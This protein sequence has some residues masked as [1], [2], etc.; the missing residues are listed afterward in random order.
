MIPQPPRALLGGRRVPAPRLA[1]IQALLAVRRLTETRRRFRLRSQEL[2]FLANTIAAGCSIQARPFSAQEASDAAVAT[3]NLGLENWPSRAALPEDFLVGQDLVSVFQVGWTILHE[4]VCMH[5]AEQLIGILRRLRLGD[6]RDAGGARRAAI[7]DDEALA[8]R[9]AVAGS[10]RDGRDGDPGHAG[11]GGA[12][13]IDRRMPGDARR[14]RASRRDRAP[15]R[16][17]PVTSR[18]SRRTARSHR[19]TRSCGRC[20][21]P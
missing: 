12:A 13:R 18:S 16:S 15:A 7:R 14:H 9:R 3:C 8:R 2:A 1:R 6:G 5:A 20:P 4:E 19:S 21:R 11:M 17:A 10:R